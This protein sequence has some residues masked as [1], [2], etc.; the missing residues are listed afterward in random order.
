MRG[1]VLVISIALLA[2][3]SK[4]ERTRAEPEPEG[5][6]KVKPPVHA[7]PPPAMKEDAVRALV[8][9]WLRAQNE[10]DFA[11][12]QALY[13]ERFTGIKRVGPRTFH[14]DRAGWLADRE[15]MFG[16]KMSVHAAGT[17]VAAGPQQAIVVFEQTWASGTYKDVGPKQLVVIAEPAGLRIGREEMVASTIVGQDTE[18]AGLP[19]EAY[20][21][22]VDG[23]VLIDSAADE[24][25]AEGQPELVSRGAPAV[26]TRA[27]KP[28]AVP[29]PLRAWQGRAVVVVPAE[30]AP[31]AATVSS[32]HLITGYEPHWGTLQMWDGDGGAP[33]SE[34]DVAQEIWSMGTQRMLVGELQLAGPCE[35]ALWVR[36][37]DKDPVIRV[38][39]ADIDSELA[40]A[41]VERTM[42]LPGYQ[43]IQK[44]YGK[45]DR[46]DLDDGAKPKVGFFHDPRAERT[47]IAVAMRAGP[48]CGDFYG[49]L[50]A[51]YQVVDRGKA[52]RELV[53]LTD[54][55]NPGPYFFPTAV[56]D[57]DRDGDVEF[58][59]ATSI[60][61]LVGTV[62]RRTEDVTYPSF[63]CPC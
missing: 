1:T 48:G 2:C 8:D 49:E 31:C 14:Y 28:A 27:A 60:V 39:A 22:L 4:K 51:V 26:A 56:I 16:K 15:R 44:D 50:W 19:R 47:F 41:A 10:G 32:L 25:W 33:V 38:P 6:E 24:A 17:K 7:E 42:K 36:V 53:L 35:G 46:W 29:E 61:R 3:N 18:G 5:T 55:K 63:D 13:A 59:D 40:V 11:A 58:I 57:A 21:P 43:L 62:Y 54:D 34:E 37:D 30:G 45:P 9:A 20:A 23:F 12:Y 52:G